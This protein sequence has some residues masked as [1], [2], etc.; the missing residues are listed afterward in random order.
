MKKIKCK[1][2][3]CSKRDEMYLYIHE[4]KTIDDLP[5]ELIALVKDLTHVIDL[6]L[7]SARKLAREDVNVVMRNL[8]EQG[9]HL[10]MPTDPFKPNLYQGD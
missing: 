2:Y 4:S 8:E 3:R 1:T 6:E 7:T 5:D 9:Y 10:Q